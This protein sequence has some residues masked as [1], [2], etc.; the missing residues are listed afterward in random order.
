MD[1]ISALKMVLAYFCCFGGDDNHCEECLWKNTIECDICAFDTNSSTVQ[2]IVK[3]IK[4]EF[5]N[6]NN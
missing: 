6:E 3:I 2:E 4:E 1:K 5:L